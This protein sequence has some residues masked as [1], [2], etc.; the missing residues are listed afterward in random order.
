MNE[1]LESIFYHYI[2]E[3]QTLLNK[4]R[5]EFF[6]N[7]YIKELFNKAKSYTVTL[8][9]PPLKEDLYRSLYLFKLQRLNDK[10]DSLYDKYSEMKEYNPVWLE[11]NIEPWIK[12]K[13]SEFKQ[14]HKETERIFQTI[15]KADIDY[16]LNGDHFYPIVFEIKNQED[17][18]YLIDLN[19]YPKHLNQK[20]H[21]FPGVP[22]TRIL[23]NPQLQ[24]IE[25]NAK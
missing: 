14:T 9:K 1:H 7:V 20:Y 25:L 2:L 6:T 16:L 8:G 17:L 19:I 5:P 13:E 11:E 4:T 23:F 22:F 10:V 21:L 18:D 3:N 12:I 15:S 24:T